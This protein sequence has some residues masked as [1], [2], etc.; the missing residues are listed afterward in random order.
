MYPM[1]PIIKKPVPTAWL[2]LMNSRLSAGWNVHQYSSSIFFLSEAE[3]PTL[4]ASVDELHAIFQKL[5]R[6]IEQFLHLV[7]HGEELDVGVAVSK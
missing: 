7:W 5:P 6:H 1:N 2:I 3:K 4:L